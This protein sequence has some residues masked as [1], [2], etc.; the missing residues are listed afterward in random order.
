LPKALIDYNQSPFQESLLA[1][2]FAMPP[3]SYLGHPRPMAKIINSFGLCKP[4]LGTKKKYC[5]DL[6]DTGSS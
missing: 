2:I 3:G 1:A 6:L 5:Q 4:S